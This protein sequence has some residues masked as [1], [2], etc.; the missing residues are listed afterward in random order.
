MFHHLGAT[1]FWEGESLAALK[2]VG[3]KTAEKLA[4][5][6]IE[7][8]GD[9]KRCSNNQLKLLKGACLTYNCQ[10]NGTKIAS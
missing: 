5:K 6:G 7:N 8:I 2:G 10:I 4:L 3:S 9:L 1:D